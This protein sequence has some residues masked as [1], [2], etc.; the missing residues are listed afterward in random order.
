MCQVG[1]RLNFST[2]WSANAVSIFHSCGLTK[3]T[4]AECSRRFLLQGSALSE[5]Q[6][7]KFAALVRWRLSPL[8]SAQLRRAS[9]P[10]P[11]RFTTV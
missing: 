9:A 4:R 1:P 2:A 6:V 8:A 3:I 7:A 5:E 11:L 10:T